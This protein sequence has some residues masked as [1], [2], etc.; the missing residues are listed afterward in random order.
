M[1]STPDSIAR[2]KTTPKVTAISLPTGC[3]MMRLPTCMRGASAS[4]LGLRVGSGSGFGFGA[5]GVGWGVGASL[6]TGS[7]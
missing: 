4:D 6:L 7:G 3:A 1:A 2:P 5:W